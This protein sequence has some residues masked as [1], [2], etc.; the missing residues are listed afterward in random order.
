MKEFII[1][2]T[3]HGETLEQVI[4]EKLH[5]QRLTSKTVADKVAALIL[6]RR[7]D[8]LASVRVAEVDLSVAPD[9]SRVF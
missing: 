7:Q 4:V 2:G 8:K 1:Y 6:E 5:G 3:L 9:F